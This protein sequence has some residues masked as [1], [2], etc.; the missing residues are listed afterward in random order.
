MRL[1]DAESDL[2]EAEFVI[3]GPDCSNNSSCAIREL[4]VSPTDCDPNGLYYLLV[5][6]AAVNN[7]DS[8][9]LRGNGNYYGRFA[10]EDLPVRIGPFT[11]GIVVNELVLIDSENQD[12]TAAKEF[13]TPNCGD[14]NI[15][16]TW[17]EAECDPSTN[18]VLMHIEFFA[19]NLIGNEL[20]LKING[21]IYD[22]EYSPNG[23]YLIVSPVAFAPNGVYEILLYDNEDSSC[24]DVWRFEPDAGFCFCS[25]DVLEYAVTACQGDVFYI[26][27][28]YT[29]NNPTSEMHISVDGD[30]VLGGIFQSGEVRLGPFPGDG[31]VR[32]VKLYDAQNPDCIAEFRVESPDC[33]STNNCG[34]RELIVEPTDCDN[35][36]AFYLEVDAIYANTSDSFDLKGNG[37]TYGRF[38][39]ADLPIRLGPFAPGGVVNELV[40]I[41]VEFQN[42]L[43]EAGFDTPDCLGCAIEIFG[44]EADCDNGLTLYIGYEIVNPRGN[45]VIL[46]ING[47][48]Y[49]YRIDPSGILVVNGVAPNSNNVYEIILYD[50]ENPNCADTWRFESPVGPCE[51]CKITITDLATT[52]CD[53]DV[54][55]IE[56]GFEYDNPFSELHI[57]VNG[58]F[59]MGN[60]FQSGQVRLGPFIGDGSR[61]VL[62]LYDAETDVC[63]DEKLVESPDCVNPACRIGEVE[64]VAGP[65]NADGE[66]EVTLDF[67]YD[68]VGSQGFLVIGGGRFYGQF[69]YADLPISLGGG[70]TE[71]DLPLEFNVF[72]A[73]DPSCING[74]RI[75]EACVDDPCSIDFQGIE[76]PFCR[77]DGDYGVVMRVAIDGTPNDFVI[78]SAPNG[79]G[80]TELPWNPDG[81]YEFII[82]RRLVNA[83]T[84]TIF[85]CLDGTNCCEDFTFDIPDCPI[86]CEIGEMEVIP[87]ECLSER[88]YNIRLRASFRN[89]SDSFLVY[90]AGEY[91]GTYAFEGNNI[92]DRILG[93]IEISSRVTIPLKIVDQQNPDCFKE[94]EFWQPDCS[95]TCETFD[96]NTLRRPCFTAPDYGPGDVLIRT[97]NNFPVIAERYLNEPFGAVCIDDQTQANMFGY[98]L[99]LESA[100]VLFDLNSRSFDVVSL[101]FDIQSL[102]GNIVLQ[103]NDGMFYFGSVGD[104]PAV[105]GNGV[106]AEILYAVNAT[107]SYRI[108][109]EGIIETLLIGGQYIALDGFCPTF[110]LKATS[111][112]PGDVNVDNVANHYD[113]LEIGIAFGSEGPGRNDNSGSWDET[114]AGDWNQTFK[115]G[116]NYKH[117]DANGDG[118]ID[119]KDIEVL[120]N[121]FGRRHGPEQGLN[122]PKGTSADPPIYM[123]MDNSDFGSGESFRIPIQL[124]EAGNPVENFYGIAFT[125]HFDPTLIKASSFDINLD[126]AWISGQGDKIVTIDRTEQEEG[127]IHLAMSR[128][129]GF[130]I[131]GSGE[132][133]YVIGIIDDILGREEFKIEIEGLKAI[134]PDEDVIYLYNQ[135]TSGEI[136]TNTNNPE[137]DNQLDVWPNPTSDLLHIQMNGMDIESLSIQN[138]LGQVVYEERQQRRS[139][140]IPTQAWTNG[141]YYIRCVT[142]EGILIR[143]VE[144]IHE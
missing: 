49:T 140:S 31:N 42:C 27:L 37:R 128:T 115:G 131:T 24:Q 90:L 4:A 63:W 77:A 134:T 62:R 65:C 14:C 113:L 129:D 35:N 8:F 58:E 22:Y 119:E 38:A 1:Y 5:D 135:T 60:I 132:V 18:S 41:D 96:N 98:H 75:I 125:V 138:A 68:N 112:W 143:P 71:A 120:D 61:R 66:F 39:Y 55:Y 85:F 133:G 16:I 139:I 76:G 141:V 73:G 53:G 102:G 26:E 13:D 80:I 84:F 50:N 89:P 103:V 122:W 30:F 136:I 81:I 43:A 19:D 44:V 104:L 52:D 36:G 137:L 78:I 72:D 111:V 144:V 69:Q 12:C 57:S 108:R 10:Y 79:I 124:G 40:L 20:V 9:D 88:T 6:A 32:L 121:N 95:G 114:E 91:F 87:N 11:P 86:D 99:E 28:A 17:V 45:E 116:Q 118:R 21:E 97:T 126:Q 110:E 83:N 54:F 92:V 117:S 3:E 64:A 130:G 107:R 7:S 33:N 56:V 82:P 74:G 67:N 127:L 47:E 142:P 46:K 59:V 25:I 106:T 101:E 15:E 109:L 23:D 94:V 93:P 51:D 123:D 48:E 2:C 29:Y 70:F 105:L 34:I 100:A